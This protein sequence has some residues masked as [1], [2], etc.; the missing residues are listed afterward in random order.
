MTA[1]AVAIC[2]RGSSNNSIAGA[3]GATQEGVHP[4][5][6]FPAS[7]ARHRNCRRHYTRL[8]CTA[9]RLRPQLP[10]SAR[11]RPCGALVHC[12]HGSEWA[13]TAGR[14]ARCF[15]VQ[16]LAMSPRATQ[17]QPPSPSPS[18]P[19]PHKQHLA[20][21]YAEWVRA[22]AQASGHVEDVARFLAMMAPVSARQGTPALAHCVTQP[23][24]TRSPAPV[25]PHFTPQ[26][27]MGESA[28]ALANTVTAVHDVL[29]LP[30]GWAAAAASPARTALTL[31]ASG[32]VVV[33]LVARA[34]GGQRW[35]WRAILALEAVRTA[36][37]LAL[38]AQERGA[39]DRGRADNGV[40]APA[41]SLVLLLG[42]AWPRGSADAAVQ[43]PGEG[44]AGD[45]IASP[46]SLQ[47][48]AAASSHSPALPGSDVR[49]WRGGATGIVLPVSVPSADVPSTS[50]QEG[51]RGS[52]LGWSSLLRDAAAGASLVAQAISAAGAD[53]WAGD[54]TAARLAATVP[55]TPSQRA[56][57]HLAAAWSAARAGADGAPAAAAVA[58]P[59]GST[60]PPA[61][62]GSYCDDDG[63]VAALHAIGEVAFVV[64]PLVYAIVRMIAGGRSWAPTLAA[65][66]L[67]VASMRC[68]SVAA[69]AANGTPT[70]V[71]PLALTRSAVC[72]RMAVVVGVSALIHRAFT[73]P[74]AALDGDAGPTAAAMDVIRHIAAD[75]F[76]FANPPGGSPEAALTTALS[77]PHLSIVATL[78]RAAL[79][80]LLP[81]GMGGSGSGLP[82]LQAAE[83][84]RRR[85]L[86]ALYLLRGKTFH[87]ITAPVVEKG[88]GWMPLVGPLCLYALDVARYLAAHHFYVS[89]S[90]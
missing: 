1:A 60:A 74:P 17:P 28:Y 21:S 46:A 82:P 54:V 69:A 77:H 65:L 86:W 35:R 48:P 20:A 31:L 59:V 41:S 26:S 3:A 8:R 13:H 85:S 64:R 80:L 51:V 67:D 56:A 36:L 75:G 90:Q 9:S 66:A 88:V 55:A 72:A 79:W 33:E 62:A 89:A 22:N 42:G 39:A 76:S 63:S 52:G 6:R 25:F 11:A 10:T 53:V 47:S 87:S 50:Q 43:E 16:S 78:L 71:V 5:R 7:W 30:G 18:P 12:A 61:P 34:L 15:G 49:W 83:L 45:A 14:T 68:H 24:H 32:D 70:T 57:S 58:A 4:A 84:A 19:R 29:R 81:G 23:L 2:T 40:G 27:H 44:A 38:L 37:R 73:P